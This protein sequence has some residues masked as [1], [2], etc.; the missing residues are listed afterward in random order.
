MELRIN[1]IPPPMVFS[2]NI[3]VILFYIKQNFWW[4]A[5]FALQVFLNRPNF[6]GNWLNFDLNRLSAI[7]NV[8]L[9]YLNDN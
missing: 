8:N 4:V 5:L 3:Y 7:M 1:L 2:K 6:N 9:E